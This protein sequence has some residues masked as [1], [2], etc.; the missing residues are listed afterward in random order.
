MDHN[1]HEIKRSTHL[2]RHLMVG[3]MI[4]LATL[5]FSSEAFAQGAGGRRGQGKNILSRQ[6]AQQL[7]LTPQQRQQ[8]RGLNQEAR[9]ELA[10]AQAQ[11]RQLRARLQALWNAPQPQQQ[12]ILTL[13]RELNTLRQ[14]VQE[15]R[16]RLRIATLNVLT[17]QQRTQLNQL[18]QQRQQT[19]Q[20]QVAQRQQQRQSRIAQRRQRNGRRAQ[21]ING[22]QGRRANPG[23]GQPQSR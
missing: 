14:V 13:H 22:R 8:I 15:R 10:P 2:K 3:G 12:A 1:T 7:N 16:I 5:M 20:A 18:R 4:A 6:V 23:L 17:P 19:R 11:V 9:R 21:G